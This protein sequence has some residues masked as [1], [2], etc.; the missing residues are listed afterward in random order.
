MQRRTPRS[1]W[2]QV[3]V[4]LRAVGRVVVY[5]GRRVVIDPLVVWVDGATFGWVLVD[6]FQL[7]WI[8]QL[9][10]GVPPPPDFADPRWLWGLLPPADPSRT[11]PQASRG[12]GDVR[13][14][15]DRELGAHT[16]PGDETTPPCQLSVSS[17]LR[18]MTF[19][20]PERLHRAS[21]RGERPGPPTGAIAPASAVLTGLSTPRWASR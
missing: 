17:P 8:S 11:Q 9:L 12:P 19:T 7:R 10:S 3:R 20:L 4:S 16:H 2:L 1:N 14:R 5:P 13:H 15:D 21:T 18:W 6:R